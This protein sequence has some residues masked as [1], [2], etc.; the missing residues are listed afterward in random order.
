MMIDMMI[1]MR[2]LSY[3]SPR[4][5]VGRVGSCRYSDLNRGGGLFFVIQF[6][7]HPRPLPATRCARVGRG[8]AQP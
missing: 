2:T 7:P 6:S 8:G 4:E 1:D 3:P 5:A